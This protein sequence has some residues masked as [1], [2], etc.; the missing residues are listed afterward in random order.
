MPA[1]FDAAWRHVGDEVRSRVAHLK[2][3]QILLNLDDATGD[4]LSLATR[5]RRQK[6]PGDTALR[7]GGE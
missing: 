7:H 1:L 6:P 2:A 5:Q 3:L 4:R